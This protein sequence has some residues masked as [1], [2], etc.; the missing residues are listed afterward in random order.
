MARGMQAAIQAIG[1]AKH[2]PV[3][4]IIV[5]NVNATITLTNNSATPAIIGT[6]PSPIPCKVF[7]YI[8]SNPRKIKNTET[9]LR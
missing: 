8:N 1:L 4:P 7:L 6:K 2:I 3:Y 9:M 5:G